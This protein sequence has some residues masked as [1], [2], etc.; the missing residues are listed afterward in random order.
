MPERVVDAKLRITWDQNVEQTVLLAFEDG[1]T[2]LVLGPHSDDPNQQ[3]VVLVWHGSIA[4][5]MEP[6]PDEAISGHRLYGL[7]LENVRWVGEV[8]GSTLIA[9]FEQQNRVHPRH[10]PRRFKLLRHWIV[11]LK[12]ATVEVVAASCEVKRQRPKMAT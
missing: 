2:H 12:G 1:E 9:G 7:G 5:R 10:N 4:T 3:L 6:P 8:K 11:L